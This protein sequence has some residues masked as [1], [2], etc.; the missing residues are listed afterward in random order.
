MGVPYG[1]ALWQVADSPQQNGKFKILLKKAKREL[2]IK[3]MD[4]CQ[5]DMHLVRTDIIPLVHKCWSAS[6]GDVD[7]NKRAIAER[8]WGPYNRNLLLHPVIRA[9][10]TELMIKNEKEMCIFPQKRLNHLLDIEYR[11]QGNGMISIVQASNVDQDR[12]INMEGGA[13]S[14]RVANTIMSDLDRQRARERNQ[15]LKEEGKTLRERLDKIKKHLTAATLTIGGRHYHMDDTVLDKVLDRQK[16]D[17]DKEIEKMRKEHLEHAIN[18]Y[19]DEMALR[20]NPFDDVKKWACFADI[21]NYLKPLKQNGDPA[22]PTSRDDIEILYIQWSE[23]RRVQIVLE[24]CVMIKFDEWLEK[25]KKNSK[26]KA[27]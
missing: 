27:K 2:F 20:K 16:H 14:R 11:D 15:K 3:R 4:S 7:A 22:W 24:Q 9:S 5:Q 1:T 6:F 12:K 18:C 26:G 8:G 21:K 25:Q 10:M 19:K 23:R 17:D 13:T